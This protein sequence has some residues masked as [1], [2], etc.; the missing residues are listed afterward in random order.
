MTNIVIPFIFLILL[1]VLFIWAD[2]ISIKNQFRIF[3][4][5]EITYAWSALDVVVVALGIGIVEMK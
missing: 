1:L 5:T 4:W 2:K 3:M